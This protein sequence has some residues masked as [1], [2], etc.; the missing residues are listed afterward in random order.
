MATKR[1]V[2]GTG[3]ATS[4]S[5]SSSGNDFVIKDGGARS[6][7]DTGAVRDTAEDKPRFSLISPYALERLA[8]VYTRGAVKYDEHNWVKGMP[9]GRYLDSAQRHIEAFKR[10]DTDED[11]LAQA[12][13]NLFS[14]I[15]HQE[16]GPPGLDDVTSVWEKK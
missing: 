3:S 1:I 10:G 6:Q 2:K 5:R 16:A 9:Y 14:I 11:H 13:W 12:A 8:M 7:F 4:R 15:H